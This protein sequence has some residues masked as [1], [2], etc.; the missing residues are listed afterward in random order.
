MNF[1]NVI[2]FHKQLDSGKLTASGVVT[3]HPGIVRDNVKLLNKS[4]RS[5]NGVQQRAQGQGQ[6]RKA[7]TEGN[8]AWR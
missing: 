7:T 8:D 6:R 5:S 4:K 1:G 3:F 2:D